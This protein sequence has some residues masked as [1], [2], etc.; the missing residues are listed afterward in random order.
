MVRAK[1]CGKFAIV[2]K[3]DIQATVTVV[4]RQGKITTRAGITY[5]GDKNLA[6]RLEGDT[7]ANIEACRKVGGGFAIARREA[8]G[9]VV[10]KNIGVTALRFKR[11]AD[12][13]FDGAGLLFEY[14]V[15]AFASGTGQ[16]IGG[17]NIGTGGA[18]QF[19]NE[20]DAAGV[21]GDIA[22][23]EKYVGIR[24][25]VLTQQGE[26]VV[27][28]I[29]TAGI[30]HAATHLNSTVAAVAEDMHGGIAVTAIA[31]GIEH[32][33][34]AIFVA[35][36]EYNLNTRHEAIDNFLPVGHTLVDDRQFTGAA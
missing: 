10:G 5:S 14:P 32:F 19:A 6:V 20:G 35:L 2:I 31:H 18:C 29:D 7:F 15:T 11:Q 1:G 4:A 3:A 22:A 25:Q 24:R 23:V 26:A 12:R 8:R 21:G 34:E 9:G 30:E 13:G 28:G 17:R 36:D 16:V 33:A 27:F